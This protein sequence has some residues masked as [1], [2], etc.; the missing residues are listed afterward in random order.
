V[1]ASHAMLARALACNQEQLQISLG[2]EA[3]SERLCCQPN[4]AGTM[5]SG[6]TSLFGGPSA[7]LAPSGSSRDRPFDRGDY[8]SQRERSDRDRERAR[9]GDR[10]R[11]GMLRGC[12][13]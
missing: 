4:R 3:S 11:Y 6:G 9:D 12:G 2:L 10:D 5:S 13:C 8:D 7:D 1:H